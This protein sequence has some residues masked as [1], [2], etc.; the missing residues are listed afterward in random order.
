MR[1][2]GKLWTI[3]CLLMATVLSLSACK[4][5]ANSSSSEEEKEQAPEKL[6]VAT[7]AKTGGELFLTKDSVSEYKIVLPE[8]AGE[9]E[10]YAADYLY[11]IVRQATG[12][13]LRSVSDTA[14]SL[15]TSA[16]CLSLPIVTFILYLPKTLATTTGAIHIAAIGLFC[17]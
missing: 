10:E 6:T 13:K 16:T 12:T 17:W 1:K 11:D 3:A 15:I 2:M 7:D 9:A 5:P 14:V 8:N 4:A